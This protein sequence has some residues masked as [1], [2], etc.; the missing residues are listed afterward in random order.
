MEGQLLAKT[1]PLS[2]S[3]TCSN[4]LFPITVWVID[5][6]VD[7]PKLAALSIDIYATDHPDASYSMFIAT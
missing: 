4:L 6:V 1:T 5:A 2:I 7:Y 3:T